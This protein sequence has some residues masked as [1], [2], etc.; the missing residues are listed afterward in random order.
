MEDYLNSKGLCQVCKEEMTTIHAEVAPGL[1]VFVCEKCLES[2]KQNFIW[3]CVNCGNVY[4]RP[5]SLV[6]TRPGDRA[7]KEA[8]RQCEGLQIIQGI[9]QCIECAP[10]EIEEFVTRAKSEKCSGHC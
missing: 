9:D 7:L 4:I 10:D 6:L 2:A 8:Y 5:K 1:H 3:I